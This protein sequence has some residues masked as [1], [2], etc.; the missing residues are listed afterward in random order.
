MGQALQL[1]SNF[2]VLSDTFKADTVAVTP[3]LYHRPDG[4]Y[5]IVPQNNWHTARI[6]SHSVMMFITLGEGTLNAEEPVRGA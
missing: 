2:V 5:R 3:D 6:R 4:E 1:A